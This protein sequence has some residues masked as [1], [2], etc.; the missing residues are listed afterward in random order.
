MSSQI[1]YSEYAA[2]ILWT[3]AKDTG[4]SLFVVCGEFLKASSNGVPA[5]EIRLVAEVTEEQCISES[6]LCPKKPTFF[7]KLVKLV[8]NEDHTDVDPKKVQDLFDIL[9]LSDVTK[10]LFHWMLDDAMKYEFESHWEDQWPAG[11]NPP[12][13]LDDDYQP[14][15]YCKGDFGFDV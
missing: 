13:C 7:S 5:K 6:V 1:D 15:T 3:E 14:T 2:Y 8:L 11:A 12:R 9:Q 4:K 10:R